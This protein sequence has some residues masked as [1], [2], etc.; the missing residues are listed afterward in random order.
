PTRASAAAYA[1]IATGRI[2]VVAAWSRY[3]VTAPVYGAA[4]TPHPGPHPSAPSRPLSD[5]VPP[6]PDPAPPFLQEPPFC[7]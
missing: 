2:G 6:D 4:P 1:S 7:P 5:P 3:A